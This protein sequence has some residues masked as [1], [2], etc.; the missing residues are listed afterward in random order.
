MPPTA[1]TVEVDGLSISD[2][3][4]EVRR[5]IG[6]LP[7]MN[8][9]YLDMNV[10]D[11][12]EYSARLHGMADAADPGEGEGNGRRLRPGGRPP[13]GHRRALEGVPPARRPRAGDDPRPRGP[14]PGRADQR[15]RPEP[16]R[17]DPQADPRARD[18]QRRSSSRR[19][20]CR[21]CRPPATA[22][23]SSTRARSSPTGPPSS[24]SASSIGRRL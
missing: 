22:C 6:Y 23:S 1:G 20:S 5:K 11:Y 4:L 7:E 2:H 8:P 18:G 13:Q 14:D 10:L 9:L 3:S 21:R 16:D 17:G 24:C 19:T 12:L 15:P